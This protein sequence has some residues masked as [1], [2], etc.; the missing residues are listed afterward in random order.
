MSVEYT[1]YIYRPRLRLPK[2]IL[3]I[4][5]FLR[6]PYPYSYWFRLYIQHGQ[7]PW[8][9][10]CWGNRRILQGLQYPSTRGRAPNPDFDCLRRWASILGNSP[11]GTSEGRSRG[12]HI[13]KSIHG[14]ADRTE[15][16]TAKTH[17]MSPN[18][19]KDMFFRF[20]AACCNQALHHYNNKPSR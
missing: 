5:W 4:L 19:K 2:Q 16:G 6:F 3:R 18:S 12:P 1:I 10:Q 14:F 7:G 11:G 9:R 20:N 8:H 13:G 17:N 15:T